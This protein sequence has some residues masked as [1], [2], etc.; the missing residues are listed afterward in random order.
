MAQGC[1]GSLGH[2]GER[3]HG[4][5]GH[6][7]RRLLD[8]KPHGT[9]MLEDEGN[10]L[11]LEHEVQRHRY[12]AELRESKV[13]NDELAAVVREKRY[14]V[15]LGHASLTQAVRGAVHRLIDLGIRLA[16]AAPAA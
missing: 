6:R 10:L 11:S 9:R 7:G 8:A 12:R 14:A 2:R 15:A 16:Q 13:Q 1:Q 4:P 5:L 3:I